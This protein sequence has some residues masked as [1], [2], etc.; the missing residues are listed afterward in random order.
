MSCMRGTGF[1]DIELLFH[2]QP[3]RWVLYL[4]IQKESASCSKVCCV[5]GWQPSCSVLYFCTGVEGYVL[6]VLRLLIV[7]ISFV[8]LLFASS[9][10]SGPS[11]FLELRN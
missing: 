6:S 4:H 2:F 1:S 9:A 10:I 8:L 11:H 7:N 5:S 3:R